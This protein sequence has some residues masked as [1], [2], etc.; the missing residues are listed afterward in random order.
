VVGVADEV[1]GEGWGEPGSS[2][3]RPD[4][5]GG[6][7]FR[8]FELFALDLVIGENDDVWLLEVNSDPGPSPRLM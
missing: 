6:D 3:G 1:S 8:A 5:G 7:H 4:I 2:E